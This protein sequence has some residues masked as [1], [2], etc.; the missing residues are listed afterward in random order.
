MCANTHTNFSA[1]VLSLIYN[2]LILVPI[3]KGSTIRIIAANGIGTLIPSVV[4][5]A[6]IPANNNV[7][8]QFFSHLLK[9]VKA[10]KMKNKSYKNQYWAIG[11]FHNHRISFIVISLFTLLPPK[12]LLTQI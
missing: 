11:S 7:I 8:C 10:T 3:P 5:I 6:C 1:L 4:D 9:K 12:N 2:L